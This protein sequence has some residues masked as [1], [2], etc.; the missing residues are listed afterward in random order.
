MIVILGGFHDFA[1]R[2]NLDFARDRTAKRRPIGVVDVRHIRQ[3]SLS[4]TKSAHVVS[5]E[6]AQHIDPVDHRN[7]EHADGVE[8]IR[9]PHSQLTRTARAHGH[10]DN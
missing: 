8:Q 6:H 7:S 10:A 1:G 9:A 2:N 5:F 4:I 3:N